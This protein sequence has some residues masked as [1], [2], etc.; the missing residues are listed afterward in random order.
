[1]CLYLHEH[2]H[3]LVSEKKNKVLFYQNTEIYFQSIF[4]L[5]P[6]L[7]YKIACDCVFKPH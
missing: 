2:K 1:M 3:L 6:C 7:W 5:S 4:V